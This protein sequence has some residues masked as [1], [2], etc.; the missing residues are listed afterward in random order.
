MTEA[1]G[2]LPLGIDESDLVMLLFSLFILALLIVV[3]FIILPWF[4]AFLGAL[5]IVFGICYGVREL[6]RTEQN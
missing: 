3:M 2:L 1:W 5:V 4:Y 6:K